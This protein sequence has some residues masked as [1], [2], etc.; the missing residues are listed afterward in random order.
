[1]KL[2]RFQALLNP[3]LIAEA[4]NPEWAS[5]P[6][7]GW[8]SSRAIQQALG[9]HIVTQIR[10]ADAFERAGVSAKEFTAID[11]EA[12][13]AP[14][15]KFS[16]WLRGGKGKAW[17]TITAASSLA[18]YYFEHLVWQR[19][20]DRIKSGEFSL[21]HRI[22]PLSPT[23]QS[24]L[25]SR[26]RR[27]G[28]PFVLGPLNGGVPWPA[29]FD[30]ERRREHEWLSYVRSL[31][32]LLPAYGSTRRCAAAI[33]VGSQYTLSQI[34]A[35]YRERVVY[36]P[37]N[38]LDL[39]RFTITRTRAASRPLRCLFLGRLVP[40]KGA[41]ILIEAI[42]PLARQGFL[43]LVIVGDGP[44]RRTL[45]GLVAKRGISPQVTFTGQVPHS[46]VQSHLSEADLLTF[47]SIREFGGAVII[48]AMAV[49]LA[50]MAVSYG[51]PAELMTDSTAF[52]IPIG[53]RG[54]LI[55]RFRRE[56]MRLIDDPSEIDRKAKAARDRA[57]ALF[58]WD[59]K[60][61]QIAEVYRWVLGER[62]GKPE[63]DFS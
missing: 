19:F 39:T 43:S 38:G 12:I 25:A 48:E 23:T 3:L 63:F 49:G 14:L 32:R 47:P 8:S 6:L 45:E 37:E 55:E 24:T 30:R 31:Y 57:R 51:G 56:I 13:A 22:T 58:T 10:N 50:P 20:G 21:V 15:W 52:P 1:L 2:L 62:H 17:T 18:Y 11:S 33:I 60:A 29:G 28:V 46:D 5:V 61:S 40:Y 27:A 36:I 53:G 4:A 59:T 9:G 35:K 16:D 44:E 7:V 34:P 41:D 54:Q 26:C 42:A